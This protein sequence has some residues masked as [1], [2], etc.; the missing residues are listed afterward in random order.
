MKKLKKLKMGL[1][2]VLALTMVF[3]GMQVWAGVPASDNGNGQEI[4]K[5]LSEENVEL[6][7]M[8]VSAG[9][10]AVEW[11]G[12]GAGWASSIDESRIKLWLLMEK[13][14]TDRKTSLTE[15]IR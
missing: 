6:E 8:N 1:C 11:H 7:N 9:M 2:L 10:V 15:S 4:E 5:S 14:W 12:Y 3:G 13:L